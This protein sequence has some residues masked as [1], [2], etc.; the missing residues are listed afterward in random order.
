MAQE[1]DFSTLHKAA[2]QTMFASLE[3][4][5]DPEMIHQMKEMEDGGF[6]H[7]EASLMGMGA[8][9]VACK[10]GGSLI[11]SEK[12]ALK[13]LALAQY[14]LQHAIRSARK[15]NTRNIS[16]RIASA[17]ATSLELEEVISVERYLEA[18]TSTF[19]DGLNKVLLQRA[20]GI[21]ETQLSEHQKSALKWLASHQQD[22]TVVSQS[23]ESGACRIDLKS[24]TPTQAEEL[25]LALKDVGVENISKHFNWQQPEQHSNPSIVVD[26]QEVEKALRR[27]T[28]SR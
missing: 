11:S 6:T 13:S 19:E 26:K 9:L 22:T 24:L 12:D 3:W 21:T 5:F 7:I 23:S 4:Y 1:I 10:A 8:L 18:Y 16:N 27:G 15:A 2:Y 17:F 14:E 25:F 20:Q 28:L